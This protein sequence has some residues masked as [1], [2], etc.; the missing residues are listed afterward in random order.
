MPLFAGLPHFAPIPAGLAFPD[1][2]EVL[3]CQSAGGIAI[4]VAFWAEP[5]AASPRGTVLLLQGRA[6]F[7]EKYGEIIGLLRGRGFCVASFDWRGQGGS[8]RQLPDI[9]KG[10]VEEFS[11][12]LHD[13]DVVIE[14]MRRR[15]LPEPYHLIAHSMGGAIALLAMDR[16]GLS[17]ERAI[18]S[19]PMVR[20]A[21]A[22]AKPGAALLAKL[23]VSLGFATAFVP[24][25]GSAPVGCKPFANN[26]L[27]SDPGRYA[28]NA[29]WQQSEPR[30]QIGDPT[31]GWVDAAFEAI[32]RFDDDDF[33]AANRVP[34]LFLLAGSDQVVD[35]RAAAALAQRMRGA[36]AIPLLG[37]RHEIMMENAAIAAQFWAALDAFLVP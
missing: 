14:E 4:R 6:E 1:G 25:G 29:A 17:F 20:I 21:G 7:I 11:D 37:A 9:A 36:S 35:S 33:G 22:A 23:L 15:A 12:Y 8:G 2:G 32:A 27:T 13:L 5:Q 24:F 31:I 34:V 30:L 10:H 18:L 26:P 19:A 28:R 3:L 16:G